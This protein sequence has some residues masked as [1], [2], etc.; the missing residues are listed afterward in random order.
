M[1]DIVIF[2]DDDETV[3]F[4][5][6]KRLRRIFGEQIRVKG[7]LPENNLENM[8]NKLEAINNKVLYLIDE[9]LTYTGLADYSGVNLIE[10]IRE[11]DTK[12]PIY[13]LT[14]VPSNVDPFLGDIEFVIDKK[15]WDKAENKGKFAERFLRHIDTYKDIK[16]KQAQRFDYLLAKSLM[17]PLSEDEAREIAGLNL[18]RSKQLLD[19]AVI[20][21]DDLESLNAKSEQL[22]T[23]FHELK[24]LADE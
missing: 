18:I 23:L 7:L 19:E 24:E 8:L 4:T 12:I 9:N 6:L 11:I 16:T 13:I 22:Q 21:E 1:T 2:I 20:S 14:S 15:E 17:E 3:I 5:V 10:K